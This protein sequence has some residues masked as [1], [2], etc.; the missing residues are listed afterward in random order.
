MMKYDFKYTNEDKSEVINYLQA[1]KF[2]R[3]IDIG[4]S[5]NVWSKDYL[6][7]YVDINAWDSDEIVGFIGNICLYSTW[8]SILEDVKNNGKF[9]FAICSHTLEDISCPQLVCEMMCKIAK[10]GFIAVPSKHAELI[11]HSHVNNPYYGYIHHR[12]I[13]NKESDKF[14]AYPKLSFIE[15]IDWSDINNNYQ[16][17][18]L[19]FYWKDYFS[20][21]IA[22][23]DYMGPDAP[24]VINYFNNLRTD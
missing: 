20:L 14:V 17:S 4:A 15:H 12:W 9:D 18:E 6:T 13:Y 3:V 7:H 11:K 1:K 5:G 23:N 16:G 2:K 21:E 22:N 19:R 8:E 10:E 24:S